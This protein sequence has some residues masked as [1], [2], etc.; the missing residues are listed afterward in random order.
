MLEDEEEPL[1]DKE[2]E[3][4]SKS[5][6]I[7][8]RERERV[9]ATFFGYGEE[10]DSKCLSGR[11]ETLN[12]GAG[13]DD[14]FVVGATILTLGTRISSAISV[15]G[16]RLSLPKSSSWLVSIGGNGGG[17]LGSGS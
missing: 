13:V 9:N 14:G 1:S 10:A 17:A 11:L 6:G 16:R 2:S 7:G 4:P 5:E 12:S 8:V 15:V 3:E